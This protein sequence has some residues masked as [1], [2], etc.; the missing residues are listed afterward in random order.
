MTSCDQLCPLVA[1]MR[2]K[3]RLHM[4][5]APCG[6]EVEPEDCRIAA[7][8]AGTV[9]VRARSE[10]DTSYTDRCFRC[11]AGTF[12]IFST[13]FSG[14]NPSALQPSD[15]D[16][17]EPGRMCAPCPVGTSCP[18]ASAQQQDFGF[19]VGICKQ[20]HSGK[21]SRIAYLIRNPVYV[22]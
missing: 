17:D 15:S 18:R 13:I 4:C 12:Q 8:P 19:T 2:T 21:R 6:K 20:R 3:L 16:F 22:S 5:Q 7:C 14:Y 9:M 1:V 11:P 10:K